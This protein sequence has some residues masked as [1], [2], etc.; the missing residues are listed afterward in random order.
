VPPGLAELRRNVE[1][2]AIKTA[3]QNAHRL[4]GSAANLGATA[5]RTVLL[6]IERA[7]A[8]GD[9]A[10]AAERLDGL[11]RTWNTVQQALRDLLPKPPP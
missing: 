3:V 4:A 2:H 9:W 8:D 5:L 1:E 10:Q 11:D 6:E 7:A